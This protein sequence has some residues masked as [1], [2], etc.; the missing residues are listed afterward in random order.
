[1]PAETEVGR[2]PAAAI[3]AAESDVSYVLSLSAEQR[4]DLLISACRA[5]AAIEQGRRQSGLRPSSP[6]PWPLS[7]QQFQSTW[8]AHARTTANRD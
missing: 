3:V 1:M 5:A 2:F 4:G 7:T 6:A 8:A